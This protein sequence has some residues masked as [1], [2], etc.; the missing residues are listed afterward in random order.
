MDGKGQ[1]FFL[2]LFIGYEEIDLFTP[3][4]LNNVNRRCARYEAPMPSNSTRVRVA[5]QNQIRFFQLE[6]DHP[7]HNDDPH[8]MVT[9]PQVVSHDILQEGICY[10]CL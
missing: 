5:S 8:T 10:K 4:N 2:C 6:K 3:R 9:Q 7:L 1:D